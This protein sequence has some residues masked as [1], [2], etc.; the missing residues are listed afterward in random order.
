MYIFI[1]C[2]LTSVPA[3]MGRMFCRVGWW[4]GESLSRRMGIGK[5]Y[6]HVQLSG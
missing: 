5:N 1:K 2:G 3:V 4:W 6:V